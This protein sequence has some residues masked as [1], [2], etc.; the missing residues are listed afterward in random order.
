MEAPAP[1][2]SPTPALSRNEAWGLASV[3]ALPGFALLTYGW[4]VPFGAAWAV[5]LAVTARAAL[6][7]ALG[8]SWVG[9][10]STVCADEP[11]WL[12]MALVT[13]GAALWKTVDCASGGMGV[14]YREIMDFDTGAV[15]RLDVEQVPECR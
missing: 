13:G 4:G 15:T 14:T 1:W 11:L 9:A 7:G 10:A 6:R 3:A 5:T 8:V 12:L 2:G